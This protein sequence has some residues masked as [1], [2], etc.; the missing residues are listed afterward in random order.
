MSERKPS[1]PLKPGAVRI[2]LAPAGHGELVLCPTED[3]AARFY[4]RAEGG[5]VWLSQLELAELFQ[6]SVPNINIHIRNVLAEGELQASATVK[7]DLI[8]RTEGPRQ[9][10]RPLK[11][12]SLEPRNA[13][14]YIDK[15][16]KGHNLIQAVARVNR[17]HDAKQYGVLVDYRGI[18]QELDTAVRAYQDLESRTQGGFDLADIEGLYHSFSAEYRRL[19]S[20]HDRLWSF[21]ST[22]RNRKDIEQ[23]RQVLSPRIV[24]DDD[25]GEYDA[26][27]KRRDDFYAALTEFGLCLRTALSS[28]SFFED[29][30]FSEALIRRY[31]DDLQSFSGLRQIARRDAMETVDYSVYEEQIRRLV[32]KQVIGREVREPEGVYLVH[33]LGRRLQAEDWSEEKARNE[34]DIIRTRLRK[35]IEQDLATDPYAQKVFGQLLKEAIAEAES[36]FDHPFKQYALFKKFEDRL[37]ALETPGVPQRFD[38]NRQAKAYFG[39]LRMALTENMIKARPEDDEETLVRLA[40]QIDRAVRDSVAENSLNPQSIEASIRTKLLPVLFPLTGL[41]CARTIVDQIVHVTRLAH[42]S[43]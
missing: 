18:L 34:T 16:L 2:D 12:Y 35:T 19:P 27:Q 36:L 15:P 39:I 43:G 29:R 6:T 24:S 8:V 17:L 25:G 3:G 23:F 20:L 37:G 41:D 28:R 32:D 26:R 40:A 14:L 9:V 42:G 11:L 10:R 22:V 38:G 13:V 7:D 4:L 21:F 5:S 30:N 31:K 33:E 1:A